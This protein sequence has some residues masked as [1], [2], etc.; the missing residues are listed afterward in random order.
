MLAELGFARTTVRDTGERAGVD[1]G[2]IA[3]C[4]RAKTQLFTAV[5]RDGKGDNVPLDLLGHRA[6]AGPVRAHRATRSRPRLPGRSPAPLR[7]GDRERHTRGTPGPYGRSLKEIFA[8]RGLDRAQL[9]AE[10]ATAAF[11][12]AVPVAAS[13][14]S[15]TAHALWE[16]AFDQGLAPRRRSGPVRP[17]MHYRPLGQPPLEHFEQCLVQPGP[18]GRPIRL[19]GCGV[20]PS[21]HARCGRRSIAR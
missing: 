4:F 11:V 12:E 17:A 7:S 9:R 5:L 13:A 18:G 10:V 14:R 3:R 2:L 6:G 19:R 8:G 21:S 16:P 15:R 1:Q 20:P